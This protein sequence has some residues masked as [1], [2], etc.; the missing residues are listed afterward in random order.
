MGQPEVAVWRF[1]GPMERAGGGCLWTAGEEAVREA[2]R[3]VGPE[4]GGMRS[5]SAQ[6]LRLAAWE[7]IQCP[8]GT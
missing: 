2:S 3:C 6:E 1:Y 8:I 7:T 5:A 4:D